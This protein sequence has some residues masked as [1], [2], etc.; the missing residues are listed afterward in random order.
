M[1]SHE[2]PL[3]IED[4]LIGQGTVEFDGT[5]YPYAVMPT[6]LE[7]ALPGFLGYAQNKHLFISVQVPEKWRPYV[8]RHEL[9]EFIELA[10]TPDCCLQSL[11]VELEEVPS[12]DLSEYVTW[13]FEFFDRLAWYC[14]ISDAY[15]DAFCARVMASRDHLEAMLNKS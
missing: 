12:R 15:D 13:R 7:P 1:S 8:L 4:N 9:R 11:K 6:T 14:E 5:E 10:G 3:W 2:W